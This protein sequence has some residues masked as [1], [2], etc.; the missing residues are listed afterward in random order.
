MT[1][2]PELRDCVRI[3]NEER[4]VDHPFLRVPGYTPDQDD[5]INESFDQKREEI[6]YA[7]GQSDWLSFIELHSELHR[8]KAFCDLAKELCDDQYSSLFAHAW[9]ESNYAY[10]SEPEILELVRSRPPAMAAMMR[11]DEQEAFRLLP[12]RIAVFRGYGGD[13]PD[14]RLGLSWTTSREEAMHHAY[15]SH[16]NLPRVISGACAKAT[17]IAHFLRRKE[18]EILINPAAVDVSTDE[19]LPPRNQLRSAG[20]S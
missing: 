13:H 8:L 15:D 20:S 3:E 1:L 9:C 5:Q 4:V 14:R 11:S 7:R 18:C 19:P 17:V 12:D 2:R 16:G 6:E 10:T